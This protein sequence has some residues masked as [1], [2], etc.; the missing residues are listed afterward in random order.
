M[1]ALPIALTCG[2]PAGVGPEIIARWVNEDP[3]EA[4][5]CVAVGPKSWL[6]TLKIPGVA[7][8]ASDYQ[9]Q[10]GKPDSEGARIAWK[11]MEIAAEGCLQGRF[12]A[13]ATAPVSKKQLVDVGYP[14]PG[15]T[16]FFA[17]QWQAEATMGFVGE[18]MRVVLASWHNPLAEIPGLLRSHPDLIERAIHQSFRLCR[19]LGVDSPRIA[20]CG[21]NPHAGEAG[22]LGREELDW[23]DPL[24]DR[25]RTDYPG[26][27]RCLPSD[28]V[29]FRHLKGDF[30]AVVAL[31]HDQ[32]LGPLKTVEFDTA[33]NVSLGLPYV[34]TSPDHGTAFDIAGKGQ[35]KTTS[36]AAAVRLA[37]QL[38]QPD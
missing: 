22:L 23:I 15:Q 17:E 35:A 33:V 29:F 20:V 32:G 1:P 18:R 21:L 24:L 36:W 3:Q 4:A 34:R 14:F 38:A 7:V 2:D 10:P 27:S 31:Y 19:K 9:A 26:L 30:D 5:N 8:G 6:D 12:A 37:R 16:E 13:V 25:L 11:A 28:T